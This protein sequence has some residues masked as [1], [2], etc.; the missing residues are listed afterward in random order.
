MPKHSRCS[1]NSGASPPIRD[2]DGF[3]FIQTGPG[4]MMR[5][6]RPLPRNCL[7]HI[8]D[9]HS[10]RSIPFAA[11]SLNMSPAATHR[12]RIQEFAWLRINPDCRRPSAFALIDK[13]SRRLNRK[14]LKDAAVLLLVDQLDLSAVA[15]ARARRHFI[16]FHWLPLHSVPKNRPEVADQIGKACHRS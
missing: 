2:R 15:A 14:R 10:P 1:K 16:P 11:T 13:R 9:I 5:M 7:Q 4:T 3:A 12:L 6:Q 8:A